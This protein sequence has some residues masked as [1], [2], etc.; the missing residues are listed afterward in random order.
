MALLADL[1]VF[2]LDKLVPGRAEVLRQL[3]TSVCDSGIVL[4]L[5]S[6]S[7]PRVLRYM[8][9][10]LFGQDVTAHTR[11]DVERELGECDGTTLSDENIV[12]YSCTLE[13]ESD[14]PVHI[15][16]RIG[17]GSPPHLPPSASFV[18][19]DFDDFDP[20]LGN[21]LE[22]MRYPIIP[23]LAAGSSRNCR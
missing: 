1:F 5:I 7:T 13:S 21:I 18:F 4:H 19:V 12:E 2:A 20:F 11:E 6:T 23:P 15:L 17:G 14:H 10:R 16:R 22:V 3:G 8:A 9:M